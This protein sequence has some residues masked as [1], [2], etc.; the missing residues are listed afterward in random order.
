MVG[1][2]VVC[3][4]C[5]ALTAAVLAVGNA[6]RRRPDVPVPGAGSPGA[7]PGNGDEGWHHVHR[8]FAPYSSWM[9]GV[10]VV[11]AV[12]AATVPAQVL[13]LSL[14]AILTGSVLAAF[15]WNVRAPRSPLHQRHYEDRW[16]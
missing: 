5:A 11:T 6:R 10:I 12:L 3:L 2:A 13:E 9:A 7:D 4:I 1:F 8:T 15:V 16:D 14:L